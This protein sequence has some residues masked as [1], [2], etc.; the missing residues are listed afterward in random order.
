MELVICELYNPI[1]HC[2][3]YKNKKKDWVNICM[4]WINIKTCSPNISK[5]KIKK[6]IKLVNKNYESYTRLPHPFIRNYENIISNKNY[7]QL[8]LAKNILLDTGEIICIIKTYWIRIIQ[9]TWK[10]IYKERQ[11]I[12]QKRK[13]PMSILYFQQNGKWPKDCSIYPILKIS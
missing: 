10:R 9:R 8:H 13:N 7:L 1:L 11:K 2:Y 12:I 5:N 4:H 3:D 6:I